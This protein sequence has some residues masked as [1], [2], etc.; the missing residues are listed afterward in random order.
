[1]T[2]LSP[3]WAP[4]ATDVAH[5]GG[6]AASLFKMIALGAQVPPF[7]VL[8]VEAFR[9]HP[10]GRLSPHVRA[11]IGAAVE[12]IGTD[13]RFAVRS[14]GVA[15]DSAD[16]SFAGLF[17]TV[18]DVE[19][20]DAVCEAIETCWA[21]HRSERAAA[22]RTHRQI[23]GDDAMAVVVQRMIESEWSGVTFTADPVSQALSIVVVNVVPGKGEALVSGLVN[24]EE[25]QIDRQDGR[26]LRRS[27]PADAPPFPDAVLKQ[28]VERSIA[29][30]DRVG[31][32]QDLEWAF[33]RDELYLLQSRPIT[34][35]TG[36]FNNHAL[37]PVDTP[38]AD[39]EDRIWTRAY[40]DEVWTPPVSPLFYDV[41]NLS[42][43]LRTRL[44]NEGGKTD[45]LP[46]PVFKYYR[47]APYA[48]TA[49]L[50][51]VYRNLPPFARRAGLLDQLPPSVADQVT[52]APFRL[53]PLLRRL[54]IFEIRN[55]AKWSLAHNAAFLERSWA[56]FLR[57]AEA[58]IAI[59]RTA[60]SDEALEAHIDAIWRL[61][62]TVGVECEIAVLY[63]AH[64]LRLWL[65]GILD[66][67]LG[68]GNETYA[69]VS[70]GL[71]NSET[72]RESETLWKIADLIRQSGLADRVRT[73]SWI[74]FSRAS[75]TAEIV[76]LVQSFLEQHR[77]RGANYKDIVHPR[78]GERPEM[79]WDQIKA[80]ADNPGI[81]PSEANGRAAAVRIAAK[82]R[83][84][85]ALKGWRRLY[86]APLLRRLF[87][88]N[89]TYSSIR[90][91]HRFYY[92][93]VWWLVRLAYLEK[94]RRL[95]DAGKL[96]QQEDVFFLV[97]AEIEQLRTGSL[98]SA[99]AAERITSRRQ[100]WLETRATQPPKYLRS[101][102]S[103]YAEGPP[104]ESG[105]RLVGIGAS[106][107]QV[108]GPARIAHDVTDLGEL[109]EG[110]ILITR[111]TD[112]SWTPAFSR[113]AGL[114]L[115]TGGALA[116]GASLCREFGLPCVTAVEQATWLIR[117]GDIIAI[118]GGDG[119]VH[120][121]ERFAEGDRLAI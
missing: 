101:G 104:I 43:H 82:Q 4:E 30:A 40:A 99:I 66:R 116:H 80:L 2:L 74:D 72:V 69:L 90:D 39:A 68:S 78:W 55:R 110:E 27:R 17:D 112:P 42:H 65:N 76:A 31:F 70:G 100:E 63:H 83:A 60:L 7:F 62:L 26:V 108:T 8:T 97:R 15:E 45:E 29:I 84:L 120:I 77:H 38:T 59:D 105:D 79:L 103:P 46:E 93:H 11:L 18:L 37:E 25:I 52:N 50:A 91:N 48:D 86:R 21:S 102:F 54:G 95:A 49:V 88:L 12:R 14:S 23:E 106:A 113:L 32:P 87:A 85:D 34:T 115:E 35:I 96:A 61:A 58:L 33:E 81:R 16:N 28:V 119:T 1:M 94:G 22:Y 118:S 73:S 67:W 20:I 109:R 53:R 117:D 51:R 41:Q 121:V 5:V 13:G 6:K 47:A 92:D 98:S 75:D 57:N 9:G 10:D 3:C 71:P 19:G 114:V 44:A 24:P 64:D 111:Q 89:E 107:G 56:D 36:V